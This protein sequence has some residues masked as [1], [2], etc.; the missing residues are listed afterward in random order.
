MGQEAFIKFFRSTDSDKDG[1]MELKF[2]KSEEFYV[3]EELEFSRKCPILTM[4]GS[5]SVEDL[6]AYQKHCIVPKNI[7]EI[8][9]FLFV[10]IC[11][12]PT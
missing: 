9:I 4:P 7:W 10:G 3:P 1:K 5:G 6:N 2:E 11:L 12:M 8:E